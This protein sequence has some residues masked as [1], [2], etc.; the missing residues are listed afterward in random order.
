MFDKF[1]DFIGIDDNYDDYDDEQLYYD[2]EEGTTKSSS[3]EAYTNLLDE[4]EENDDQSVTYESGYSSPSS[5]NSTYSSTSTEYQAKPYTSTSNS[6]SSNYQRSSRRGDNIVSMTESNFS[7]R[8][9]MRIS[10][11]EPL[12][13]EKDA[14]NVIDDIL[15]KKVVVLN[16]EMVDADMRQRIF[17]FVS[18]AVYALEGTVERVTKGIFVIS[19]KG[20]EVD[21]SVTDQISD[22]NYNQ[23]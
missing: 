19:P 4:K 12:D 9:S 7:S 1:K 11:Q 21:S 18:G 5:S 3:R 22:G 6:S 23:L 2:D 14:P 15:D 20:V 13:Y 8:S 17:D 16:L 10:I